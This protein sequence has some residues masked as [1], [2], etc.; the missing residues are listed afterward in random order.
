[1]HS[2][3]KIQGVGPGG[4]HGRHRCQPDV[5]GTRLNGLGFNPDNNAGAA[6][7]ASRSA[8]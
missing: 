2:N 8:A 3:V 7:V 5:P 6:W 1:M 4:F